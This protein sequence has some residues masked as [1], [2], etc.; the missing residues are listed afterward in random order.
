[1]KGAASHAEA[2]VAMSLGKNDNVDLRYGLDDGNQQSGRKRRK[3]Q[4]CAH[5][6]GDK[7]ACMQNGDYVNFRQP[8]SPLSADARPKLSIS[9]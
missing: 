5:L 8:L 6:D 4:R 7:H 9:W 3:K 2:P 1:M